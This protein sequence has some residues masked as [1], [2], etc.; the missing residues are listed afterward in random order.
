MDPHGRPLRSYFID[1]QTVRLQPD[2]PWGLVSPQYSLSTWWYPALDWASCG[3][4]EYMG[5]FGVLT[6]TQFSCG[7]Q[8]VLI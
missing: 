6:S 5:E 3:V 4:L 1:Q 7:S 2:T 8:D